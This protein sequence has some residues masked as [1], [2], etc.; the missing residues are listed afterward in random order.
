M[1][2][3]NK[4]LNRKKHHLNANGG[5]N[6]VTITYKSYGKVYIGQIERTFGNGRVNIS[7]MFVSTVGPDKGRW[8]RMK[9]VPF[10]LKGKKWMII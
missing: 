8:V 3:K 2:A 9:P 1:I 10:N 7:D 4:K 5:L 6:G